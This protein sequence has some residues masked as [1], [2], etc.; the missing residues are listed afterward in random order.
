MI[1][2]FIFY[3][4]CPDREAGGDVSS[5]SKDIPGSHKSVLK[6]L[7]DPVVVMVS[8]VLFISLGS[9]MGLTTWLTTYFLGFSI[10]VAYG[11]AILSVYWLF[12][13]IGILITTKIVSKY[14]EVNILFYS[15]LG[16][17]MFLAVFSFTPLIYIKITALAM[18]AMFFAAIFPLTNAIAAK[19]DPKNSGTVLGFTIAFA[20]AGSIVFQPIYGYVAEYFGKEYIAYIALGGTLIG[21]IFVVILFRIIKK[22]NTG[23]S[24]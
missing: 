12:S 20:F 5:Q 19:R 22:E 10:R 16:G 9:I 4:I 6:I 21:F 3:K 8:L 11:S 13:I 18:Q 17:I 1:F 14:K 7:K 24:I 15:C 23:I 2:I